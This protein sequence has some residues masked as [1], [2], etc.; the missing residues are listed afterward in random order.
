[1]S[2]FCLASAGSRAQLASIPQTASR[3]S[4]EAGRRSCRRD[5]HLIGNITANVNSLSR[6]RGRN[7]SGSTRNTARSVATK[8]VW[9]R[10]TTPLLAG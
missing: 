2:R 10:S 3:P 1:M 6:L 8:L 5:R 4:Q 7:P 9:P